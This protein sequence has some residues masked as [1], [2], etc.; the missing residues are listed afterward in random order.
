MEAK[1]TSLPSNDWWHLKMSDDGLSVTLTHAADGATYTL[2]SEG[3]MAA[4]ECVHR[5][6]MQLAYQERALAAAPVDKTR[7]N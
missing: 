3:L 6:T 4:A 7:P 2:P 5:I 1:F